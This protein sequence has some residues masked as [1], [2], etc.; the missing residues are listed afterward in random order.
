MKTINDFLLAEENDILKHF[1]SDYTGPKPYVFINNSHAVTLVAHADTLPRKAGFELKTVNNVITV[2]GGGI[3]G[4][5]DRA[6][7]Y[8][9]E[10]LKH[11][12]CN[13]LI[14]LGEETGGIGARH[15]ALDLEN[16]LHDCNL[17]I[18]FDR[19]GAN[20]FVYYSYSLH[21]KLKNLFED[22]GYIESYGSYSDIAEFDYIPAV[23]VSCGYYDQHTSKERLHI[24]ELHMSI[25]R[26]NNLIR[27]NAP[28]K[29][30]KESKN[31]KY[32]Y[33]WDFPETYKLTRKQRGH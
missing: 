22:Y 21:K 24:D 2:K 8:A 6:G 32:E 27:Y 29:R 12:G 26:I 16:D 9:L 10:R 30:H 14:T 4:A 18:E 1:D 20:D 33:D 3:L 25:T 28:V 13:L 7:C 17:M 5:D 23:N 11:T 31:I 15:A 19:R